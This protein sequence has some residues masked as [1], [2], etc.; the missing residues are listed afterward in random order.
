[1]CTC[2][3]FENGD[4]YFGR[5]L[6]LEYSFGEQIV[7]TPRNFH[8]RFRH[9]ADQPTHYAMIGMASSAGLGIAGR[10]QDGEDSLF[11][12]YAEAVNEEGLCMA[13]L[14]FP[15]SACYRKPADGNRNLASFELIPWLLGI[16]GTVGEAK[17]Q[18]RTL[19][20]TDDAF[21]PD[22][23]PAPLHWMLADREQC[24]VLEQTES[25]LKVFDDPAGVLTNNPPFEYHSMNLNNYLNLTAGHPVSRFLGNREP[26][27]KATTAQKTLRLAPYSQGMGSMGL[28]GDPSSASRFIRAA[29]LKWNSSCGQDELSN[30][31]QFFH[32]L[33]G[34][35]M[36]RG[37]VYTEEGKCDITLYS[38]C[39]NARAGVYYYRTYENSQISAVRLENAG[40]DGEELIGYELRTKQNIKWQNE[41]VEKENRME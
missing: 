1:M 41:S 24:L 40:I 23:P 21:L 8:L 38:C 11:P 37:S 25:G 33:D 20:I 34:V 5:N 27:T 12:L 26:G 30:V 2:I 18:I 17:E 15:G 39:V 28:P 16:C 4:F 7:V 10:A 36:T 14:N 6:D 32:I 22:M 19:N 29:F 31:S 3:T 35:A 9:A 13:G